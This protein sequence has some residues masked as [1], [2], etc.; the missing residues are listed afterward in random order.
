M[1]IKRQNSQIQNMNEA[2]DSC[3]M[4]NKESSGDSVV[5]LFSRI[6]QNIVNLSKHGKWYASLASVKFRVKNIG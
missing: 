4:F 6:L 5:S 3:S 1:I 2:W